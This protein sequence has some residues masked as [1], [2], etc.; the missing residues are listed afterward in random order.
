MSREQWLS[1]K[2]SALL[3][4]DERI[5]TLNDIKDYLSALP[6]YEAVETARMLQVPLLFDCLNDSNT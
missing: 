1:E 3:N 5:S 4:E 6:Q 2:S